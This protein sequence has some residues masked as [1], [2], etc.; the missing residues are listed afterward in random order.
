MA[1][2]KVGLVQI[3]TGVAADRK[4]QFDG[5]AQDFHI[6]IDDSVDDLI[7]GKGSALGTT[8][9]IVIDEAGHVTMPLQSCF[10]AYYNGAQS[11]KTGDDTMYTVLFDTERFDLN[12]DFASSTFTAPVTGKYL[13]SAHIGLTGYTT[14]S[15]YSNMYLVTSNDTYAEFAGTE[16]ENNQFF[17]YSIVAD[18]DASDTAIVRVNAGGEGSKVVDVADGADG[19]CFFSGCLLA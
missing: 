2:S 11:N 3:G 13:L 16:V 5:N 19:T 14:S 12:G 10:S 17:S 7:I 9:N 4:I 6:G 1:L 15:T 8:A 18:M